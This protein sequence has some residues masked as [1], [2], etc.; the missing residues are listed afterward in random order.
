[1]ELSSQNLTVFIFMWVLLTWEEQPLI[2]FR[3][4]RNIT[5]Y[6]KTNVKSYGANSN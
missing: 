1:M 6:C 5:K 3:T 4:E 2:K